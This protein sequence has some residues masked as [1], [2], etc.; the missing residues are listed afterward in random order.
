[1]IKDYFLNYEMMNCDF[2]IN[3]G[4]QRDI[5]VHNDHDEC[6]WNIT[7]ADT[8]DK[9]QTGSRVKKIEKYIDEDT[10]LLTYGDAVA[11]VN[12]SELLAYHK[13]HGKVGTVTGVHPTSRFGE[14][15][16]EA[17]HVKKFCEKPQSQLGFING[18]FF[19]FNKEFFSYL[20]TQD[21]CILEREPIEQL[22]S[23]ENLMVYQHK[24]FWQCCDTMRE[25]EHLNNLWNL[26]N[27]PW[28]VWQ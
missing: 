11:N 3:L 27:P 16:V 19:V 5:L 12:I 17:C 20:S 1:M 4:K 15:H 8:G 25:L 28:K 9:S 24:E 7:L 6:D 22:A 23:S 10:F 13:S 26:P 14:L 2:T 18:G 21:E